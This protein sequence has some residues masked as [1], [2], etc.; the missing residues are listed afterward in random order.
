[1][2]SSIVYLSTEKCTFCYVYYNK[3]E[4]ENQILMAF[5]CMWIKQ[6][7]SLLNNQV[8]N[9]SMCLVEQELP[10][11]TQ[12]LHSSPVFSWVRVTR[13]LIVCVCYVYR[14]L[15]LC[16]FSFHYCIVSS[17]LIFGFWLPI[18]YLQTLLALVWKKL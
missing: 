2:K 17:Y 10:T 15:F 8:A 12:H 6:L 13:S 7:L 5:I 4:R 9:K 16:T 11:L 14:F 1:M 3:I 18:W